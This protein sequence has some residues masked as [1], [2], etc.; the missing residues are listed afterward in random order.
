M[1]LLLVLLVLVLGWV[2]IQLL[3]GLLVLVLVLLLEG[4]DVVGL[5]L[6]LWL[7][8]HHWYLWAQAL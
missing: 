6:L 3:V 5:V 4:V 8:R 1:Q 2:K 7:R